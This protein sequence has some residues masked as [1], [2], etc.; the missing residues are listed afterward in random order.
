MDFCRSFES[1]FNS[2]TSLGQQKTICL[3]SGNMQRGATAESTSRN[4]SAQ[5]PLSTTLRLRHTKR[6][7]L[8]RFSRKPLA[9]IHPS[10]QTLLSCWTGRHCQHSSLQELTNRFCGSRRH[11]HKTKQRILSCQRTH[12]VSHIGKTDMK[13]NNAAKPDKFYEKTMDCLRRE[14]PDE[15]FNS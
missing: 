5:S 2:K 13:T 4:K 3:W 8:F 14:R 12:R 1:P 7:S 10:C 15:T 9:K 6:F 11:R